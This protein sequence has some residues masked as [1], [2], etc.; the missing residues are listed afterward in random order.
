MRSLRRMS[1]R[2]AG[3]LTGDR[4]ER[5]L[6]D[7]L[8]SHIEMQVADNVRAGMS[9]EEARRAARLKFGNVT[10]AAESYR[11]QRGLPWLEALF[12]DLRY[13]LRGLRKSPG[14]TVV[15]V[16]T[17]ALGIGAITAVFSLVDQV[18][19]A[20]PGILN[21]ERIIVVL[22]R[23][24]KLNAEFQIASPQILTDLQQSFQVFE[25]SAL[26][27]QEDVNYTGIGDPQRLVNAI[28][29]AEWFDV[30][31]AKPFLGRVFGKEEDQPNANRVVVLSYAAWV[32]L[33]GADPLVLGRTI[34]LNQTLRRIVGVMP[35]EFRW[36]Q[37]ADL[38]T[39]AGLATDASNP[40]ARFGNEHYL[41]VART[42]PNISFQRAKDWMAILTDRIRNSGP[43]SIIAKDYGW[44]LSAAPFTDI[45]AGE[46][47]K[48][49]LV[50][51]GAVAFVLL[52][53][54]SNVAGL[55]LARASARSREFAVRAALGASRGQLLR[56]LLAESLLLIVAGGGAGLALASS[57]VNLL[58]RLAPQ[59]V[60]TG[61]HAHMDVRVL[62]FCAGT[63]IASAVLFGFMPA[64][65]IS[66]VDPSGGLKND[67][68]SSTAAYGR[69]T[70]RSLLVIAETT[71][72]LMLLVAGGLFLKSFTRLASVNPGFEPRGVTTAMCWLPQQSYNSE[73]RIQVFDRDVLER[74]R[75]TQAV[76]SA[77]M[78][79]TIPFSG[80]QDS[81][82]FRIEDRPQ[83]KGEPMPYGDVV[84][85]T[86]G[87][88]RTL[89]I[90]LQRGRDFTEYDR[91]GSE[92]VVVIDENLARRYWPGEDPIGKRMGREQWHRIIGVVGHVTN[93]NLAADSGKGVYY[94]S[95]FQHAEPLVSILAKA[96]VADAGELPGTIREAVHNTDPRQAVHSFRSMEDLVANSL[97]P[98]RFGMRLVA[99][100]AATALFL[101][102]LGLY[103]VIAYSVTQR[104]REIG[105][106]IA[107]GAERGAVLRLVV[108]RGLRLAAFGAGIGVLGALGGARLIQSQLFEVS[109]ADPLTILA[110]A[111][112]LLA[113]ATLASYLPARRVLRVDP[114]VALRPE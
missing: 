74:L 53:V 112:I 50:L 99:F 55:M 61:L 87:Y 73:R 93:A 77:A 21:P 14:F 2:L 43:A 110:T 69:Q 64:W 29:T 52:I 102:A 109:A 71:L 51:F 4:S 66:C 76:E 11:G 36:P 5:E 49:L 3:A 67:E 82:I 58:L 75:N 47:R 86:P 13:A 41:A 34:E 104:T 17:L 48:P 27:A 8:A 1:K 95:M 56:G 101:A 68:R 46:T 72:A 81:A 108:G 42:K 33:F 91:E 100:F 65:Q 94:L 57:G 7:E 20:P 16:L 44:S 37:N 31:R 15:A 23:Y 22:T 79:S 18:L 90:P 103:G 70:M 84:L 85:V 60:V 92:Q 12:A 89:G 98:R 114:V 105:I 38:W 97:A 62:V 30:F 106:R 96:R 59:D 26:M 88:F 28:V 19:L 10:L 63:A 83:P 35:P 111:V 25:R 54:C 6:A 32:R 80:L 9:P 39:P 113:I 40:A 107:L 24:G 45:V 78:G